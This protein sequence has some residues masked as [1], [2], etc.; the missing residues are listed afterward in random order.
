L[1]A[2]SNKLAEIMSFIQRTWESTEVILRY[3]IDRGRPFEVRSL[4][5]LIHDISTSFDV[6]KRRNSTQV[7]VIGGRIRIIAPMSQ[8]LRLKDFNGRTLGEVLDEL[9]HR[10]RSGTQTK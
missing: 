5:M 4:S 7:T 9:E 6:Y 1:N 3:A 2:P 8:E 10:R